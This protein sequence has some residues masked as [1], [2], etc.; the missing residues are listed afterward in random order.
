MAAWRRKE[1]AEAYYLAADAGDRGKKVPKGYI[2][3]A[4]VGEEGNGDERV[5][6][7]IGVLKEPCMA[8]LLEMAAQQFGYGQPGVLR[9]PCDAQQFHQIVA[10]MCSKEQSHVG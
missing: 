6:V 4:L 2:P 7:R 3:L 8:A 1:T 10:A 5:L 9:I